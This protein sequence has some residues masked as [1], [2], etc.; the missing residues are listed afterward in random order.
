M[1]KPIAVICKERIGTG[2]VSEES[3]LLMVRSIKRLLEHESI[4][5]YETENCEEALSRAEKV[6]T[7]VIIFMTIEAL[8]AAGEMARARPEL[9][10]I[11][12]A[13]GAINYETQL[14]G[15]KIV[16]KASNKMIPTLI[17]LIKQK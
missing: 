3:H 12:L 15:V 9:S 13:G 5:V 8:E 14:S 6:G 4:E 17:A 16:E 1:E 11:L 10:I 2:D 7:K